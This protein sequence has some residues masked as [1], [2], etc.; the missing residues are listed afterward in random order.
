[1]E[2]EPLEVGTTAERPAGTDHAL[3]AREDAE[4]VVVVAAGARPWQV[5]QD[6]WLSA[7]RRVPLQRQNTTGLSRV[8]VVLGCFGGV[9]R[10]VPRDLLV[11]QFFLV[12]GV[13]GN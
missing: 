12:G 2:A 1:M 4:A 6:E 7:G 10:Y 8:L 13:G 3:G 11:G 5:P 9:L